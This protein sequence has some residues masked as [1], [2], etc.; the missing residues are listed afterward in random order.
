MD[1]DL[2]EL[3]THL[4]QSIDLLATDLSRDRP[5]LARELWRQTAW[6]P[7]P[8]RL[9]PPDR[10]RRA[11]RPLL[12]SALDAGILDERRFDTFMVQERRA[13]RAL[14]GGK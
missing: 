10:R 13:A 1:R 12:Y 7:S 11:L 2:E 8:E 5:D 4:H 3:L 6:I 14:E 9:R